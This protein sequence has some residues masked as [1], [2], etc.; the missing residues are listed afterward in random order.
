MGGGSETLRTLRLS[1]EKRKV[2]CVLQP[3]FGVFEHAEKGSHSI[4]AVTILAISV[5]N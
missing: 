4:R 2:S 3:D 5:I 1:S